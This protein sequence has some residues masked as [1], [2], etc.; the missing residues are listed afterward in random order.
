MAEKKKTSLI[1]FICTHVQSKNFEIHIFENKQFL[2]CYRS[3]DYHARFVCLQLQ[4]NFDMTIT[5]QHATTIATSRNAPSTWA[6]L[7]SVVSRTQKDY[8]SST[9]PGRV[10]FQYPRSSARAPTASK[11]LKEK[12]LATHG[13]STSSVA[14]THSPS[15]THLWVQ[16]IRLLTDSQL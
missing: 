5:R 8:T 9:R 15:T 13:T 11:H 4:M 10:P 6:I 1:Y 7:S 12:T 2:G 16:P 14:S 3:L